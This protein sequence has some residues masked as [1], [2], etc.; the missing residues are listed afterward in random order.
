MAYKL[1]QIKILQCLHNGHFPNYNW[2]KFAC[3]QFTIRFVYHNLLI[4]LGSSE[5]DIY[6]K[7][8]LNT[9]EDILFYSL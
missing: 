6:Q 2:L 5:Q 1:K 4:H 8:K 7:Q 3:E 9:Q